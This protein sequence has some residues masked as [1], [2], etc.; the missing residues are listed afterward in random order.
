MGRTNIDL[1]DRL[2]EAGRKLTGCRTLLTKH[3]RQTV[4]L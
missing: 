2:V 4:L 3:M 1:D